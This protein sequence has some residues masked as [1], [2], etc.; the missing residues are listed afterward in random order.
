MYDA[1]LNWVVNASCWEG[2]AEQSHKVRQSNTKKSQS[3]KV[4]TS[5]SSSQNNKKSMCPK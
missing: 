4:G 1:K 2:K 3:P 5:I